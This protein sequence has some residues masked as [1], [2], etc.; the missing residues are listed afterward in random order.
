MNKIVICLLS[1]LFAILYKQFD[2]MS[3]VL[4]AIAGMLYM[5][6]DITDKY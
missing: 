1:G 4:G 3:Y 6:I 5:F 2:I